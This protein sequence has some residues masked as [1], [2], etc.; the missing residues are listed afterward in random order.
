MPDCGCVC[1]CS[2]GYGEQV[3]SSVEAANDF[4]VFYQSWLK[5]FPEFAG[6]E[7]R[8][9]YLIIFLVMTDCE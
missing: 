2:F 3:S 4:V 8:L 5:L 1:C 6:R 9:S 7:V